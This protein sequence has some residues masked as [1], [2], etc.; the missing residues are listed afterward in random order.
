[1][2]DNF[3]N[4]MKGTN[5]QIQDAQQIAKRINTKMA[6]LRQTKPKLK[7]KSSKQQQKINILHVG[8]QH[9]NSFLSSHQKLWKPEESEIT[10]F[11]VMEEKNFVNPQFY[12]K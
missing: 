10:M 12:I 5:L 3:P 2:A 7:S 1:M 9:L 8:E 11:A 4:L 6:T